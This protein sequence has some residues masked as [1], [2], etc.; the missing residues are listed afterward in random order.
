MSIVGKASNEMVEAFQLF[1][2][3][4][5]QG[6]VETKV[7]V[8]GKCRLTGSE[9]YCKTHCCVPEDVRNP[10]KACTICGTV[11]KY[12]Y[13]GQFCDFCEEDEKIKR[14]KL[15]L[16]DYNDVPGIGLPLSLD[17]KYYEDMNHFVERWLDNH[18]DEPNRRRPKYLTVSKQIDFKL[19]AERIV[20]NVLE[21][22]Y[23]DAMDAVFQEQINELQA[24]LD[25]WCNDT[26]IVWF[27]PTT[28]VVLI[29]WEINDAKS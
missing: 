2:F 7:W 6:F 17:D 28:Q 21:D 18:Y 22:A 26:G 10:P 3:V 25:K 20:E 27:E 8:C 11:Q 29:D 1:K 5:D 12:L 9:N 14:G 23:E 13:D 16:I 19:D 4:P 24:L 15:K